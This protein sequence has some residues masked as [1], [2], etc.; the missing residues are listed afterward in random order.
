M[1]LV[2]PPLQL[3]LI[4]VLIVTRDRHQ[5]LLECW[6]A[7]KIQTQVNFQVVTVDQSDV[8]LPSSRLAQASNDVPS[9]VYLHSTTKGKSKGL[10]LGLQSCTAPLIA[11][12]DD[13]CLP[14]KNWLKSIIK[15]FKKSPEAG[16]VFG[17]TLPYLPTQFDGAICPCTQLSE[18]SAIFKKLTHHWQIGYGN[19]MAIRK[20]LLLRLGG[21]CEWLGP[22]SIGS[23]AEDADLIQRLLAD[24]QQL[25]YQPKCLV[26]HNRWLNTSQYQKQLQ[27]YSC[28]ETAYYGHLFLKGSVIAKVVF[29]NLWQEILFD[30]KSIR[31]AKQLYWF[32][33]R[34]CALLRGV[35]VACFYTI[36]IDNSKTITPVTS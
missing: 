31:S 3:P 11:F 2:Q 13:D 1:S 27:S 25:H 17:R 32:L 21:F 22:G 34:I 29:A 4:S 12:T 20:E 35:I 24:G 28:G 7:L 10:N 19:N 15:T 5:Q 36:K 23:N 14:D 18:Q 6:Q 16:A 30:L 33:A 26:F 8:P 9:F